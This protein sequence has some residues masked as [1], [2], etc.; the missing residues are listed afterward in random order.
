MKVKDCI[1]E[2]RKAE[3]AVDTLEKYKNGKM[4]RIAD[5]HINEIEEVIRKYID[6]LTE[7]ETS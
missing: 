3:D 2:I 6:M 4:L 1:R 5:Q 7:K